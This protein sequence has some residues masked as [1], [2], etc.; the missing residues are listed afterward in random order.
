MDLSW[1]CRWIH[2]LVY[3]NMFRL[4]SDLRNIFENAMEIDNPNLD[5]R[6]VLSIIS[7]P[8]SWHS[9]IFRK[10]NR[11]Y[12]SL[13]SSSHIK[14]EKKIQPSGKSD[15][16]FSWIISITIS[17]SAVDSA[18]R[19]SDQNQSNLLLNLKNDLAPQNTYCRSKNS[20]EQN[21]YEII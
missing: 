9:K 13:I 11:N 5:L 21:F 7:R 15:S 8:F 17:V 12:I 4:L 14:S 19:K 3:S 18:K 20:I 10:N 1:S 6:E 16:T 2:N